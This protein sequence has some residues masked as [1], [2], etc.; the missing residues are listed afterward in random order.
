VPHEPGEMNVEAAVASFLADDGGGDSGASD[1]AGAA[2]EA[3][4][5]AEETAAEEPAGDEA[6]EEGDDAATAEESEEAAEAAAGDAPEKVAGEREPTELEKAIKAKD[7]KA[8]IVALGDAA[9]DLLGGKAH[10]ALRLA[11]KELRDGEERLAKS[12]KA[13]TEQ[14]GDPKKAFEAAKKGAEG[15]DE[16][17]E[18]IERQAGTSW[19]EI[20]KY[21]NE[22]QA[23]KDARLQAKAK[24]ETEKTAAADA[25]R[26]EHEK[27]LRTLIT[28][29]VKG[30]D[31]KLLE[32]DPEIVDD[33]F[34]VMKAGWSKGINTP[35]K[36]L[37]VV[38]KRLESLAKVVVP[39]A[40]A[41][42]KVVPPRRPAPTGLRQPR[43]PQSKG[44]PPKDV[45]DMVDQ[46][47]REEGYHGR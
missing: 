14:Y 34:R 30:S 2:P 13:L 33:V 36:A 23:G 28:D 6:S 4:S 22:S 39:P 10:K 41:K 26:A 40:P 37:A 16:F 31:S 45:D 43:N 32:A 17:V 1:D 20:V 3:T 19:A 47:L 5:D 25:K 27:T 12:A 11:A 8:F 29:T 21:V 46:F 9:N 35:A 38:K 42:P 44:P 24:V 15:A 7:V 18:A